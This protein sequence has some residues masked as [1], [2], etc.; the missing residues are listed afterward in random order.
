MGRVPT[1]ALLTPAE[2]VA[3]AFGC[4]VFAAVGLATVWTSPNNTAALSTNF[5]RVS[6]GSDLVSAFGRMGLDE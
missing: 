4:D 5:V 1:T 3:N 6:P 2:R